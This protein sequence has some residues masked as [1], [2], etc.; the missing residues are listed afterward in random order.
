LKLVMRNSIDQGDEV[1]A[2][3]TK[4]T[5]LTGERA[6]PVPDPGL[7]GKENTAP[8]TAVVRRPRPRPSIVAEPARPAAAQEQA[9]PPRP[10]IEVIKGTKKENVDFP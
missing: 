9:A 1:T 4:K 2:G 8:R 10:S 6:M 7:N 3:A 5:L